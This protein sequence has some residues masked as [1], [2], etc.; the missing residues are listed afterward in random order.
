MYRYF[1]C[2]TLCIILIFSSIGYCFA[3][4][5]VTF[6]SPQPIYIDQGGYY[7]ATVDSSGNISFGSTSFVGSINSILSNIGKIVSFYISNDVVSNQAN[8]SPRYTNIKGALFDITGL[9]LDIKSNTSSIRDFINQANITLALMDN[10][11][12]SMVAELTSINQ[13]T[14]SSLSRLIVIEQLIGNQNS[15]FT[16]YTKPFYDSV[17]SKL[18]DIYNTFYFDTLVLA[19]KYV[20]DYF[21]NSVTTILHYPYVAQAPTVATKY[22]FHPVIN[23]DWLDD[24]G[25]ITIYYPYNNDN[26]NHNTRPSF[27][28]SNS[29]AFSIDGI[30]FTR[31]DNTNF[32]SDKKS[33]SYDYD[34]KLIIC[35][36]DFSFLDLSDYQYFTAYGTQLLYPVPLDSDVDGLTPFVITSTKGTKSYFELWRELYGSDDLVQSKE[37]QKPLEQQVLNDFT[38]SGNNSVSLSDA[39]NMSS[40][41]SSIKSGFNAGGSVSGLLSVFSDTSLFTWFSQEVSDEINT[42]YNPSRNRFINN[43]SDIIDNMTDHMQNIYDTFN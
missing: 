25:K 15:N 37:D 20:E 38:G 42:L 7:S 40:I 32:T 4:T 23:K 19:D 28:T 21:T 3:S 17:T 33:V 10:K 26:F 39:S 6:P 5:D 35:T 29:F 14:A 12:D 43:N 22:Y 8:G 11:L 34:N 36:F 18:D 41:S 27:S 24:D 16:N 31:I 9:L 2:F 13:S 30:T 1:L